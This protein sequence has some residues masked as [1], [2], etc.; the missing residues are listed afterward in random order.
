MKTINQMEQIKD[1]NS[2][3]INKK[4]E[5]E[6]SDDYKDEIQTEY[7]LNKDSIPKLISKLTNKELQE[8]II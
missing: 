3:T 8:V 2:S 7:Q 1:I 4:I 6:L 5:Y